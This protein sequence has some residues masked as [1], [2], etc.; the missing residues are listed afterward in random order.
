MFFRTEKTAKLIQA[1]VYI[2]SYSDK[3][4]LKSVS[5]VDFDS[6][7]ISIS[8]QEP[9]ISKIITLLKQQTEYTEFT[10]KEASA[11]DF[12]YGTLYRVTI[13]TSNGK[14]I[15]TYV[16]H[17]HS[18][19]EITALFSKLSYSEDQCLYEAGT[20]V[21]C[22]SENFRLTEGVC[23]QKVIGCEQYKS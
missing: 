16:Y 2:E 13:V 15:N 7:L 1:E 4:S 9:T 10:A 11:K 12:L 18:T 17:D 23:A 5:N 14:T 19:E 20:C 22:K 21:A 8:T 6:N 3:I